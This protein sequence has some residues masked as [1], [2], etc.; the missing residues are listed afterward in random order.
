M[1]RMQLDLYF[2]RTGKGSI[3]NKE[4][5]PEHDQLNL[6]IS[7]SN[8]SWPSNVSDLSI[9]PLDLAYLVHYGLYFGVGKKLAKLADAEV[10]DANGFD[11]M[12]V[13]NETGSND[14]PKE[15]WPPPSI[16]RPRTSLEL[17]LPE[18]TRPSMA[19]HV[20]SIVTCV[21][22][23]NCE[24]EWRKNRSAAGARRSALNTASPCLTL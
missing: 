5:R 2:E 15:Q 9:P 18:S 14:E 22:T 23:S 8:V 19:R 16:R 21:S 24:A 4:R 11:L 13:G 7:K 17:T 10:G 1:V 6:A 12:T 20:C 3:V